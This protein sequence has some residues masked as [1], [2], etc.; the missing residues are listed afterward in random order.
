MTDQTEQTEENDGMANETL[1]NEFDTGPEAEMAALKDRAK[2]LGLRVSP[3]IGLDAL[4]AKVNDALTGDQDK[5]QEKEADA[6]QTGKPLTKQQ[7]FMTTRKRMQEE[8]LAL[9]RV[10]ISCMNPDKTDWPGEIISV[11]N[12]YLGTVRKFIPFGEFTDNGY[13]VPQILLEQL[14]NRQFLQKRT[15]TDQRTGKITVKTRF[16]KE[17]SIDELEPLTQKD[18]DKMAAHQ[19]AT[20]GLDE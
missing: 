15:H 13:H 19:R 16:V 8:K 9:K 6:D 1:G 3:N 2:S 11:G 7:R 17:F 10:R 4:R 20:A 12:K 14:E 5:G 18:L